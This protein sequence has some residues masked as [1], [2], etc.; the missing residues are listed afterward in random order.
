[1]AQME[2]KAQ[3]VFKV[4]QESMVKMDHKVQRGIMA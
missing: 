1:M 4:Q 2:K 3:K